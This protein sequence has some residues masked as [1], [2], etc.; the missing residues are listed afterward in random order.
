MDAA[1]EVI[2]GCHAC[3]A[4][5]NVTAVGPF[6]NVE[7]PACGAHNRVKRVLGPYLLEQRHS[8]GG[9]STVFIARDQTLDRVV[10]LKILNE[11]WCADEKRIAAFVEEARLTASFSHP[12]VVRVFRT[13]WAYG[14]FYIAMELV[15]GPHLEHWIHEKGRIPE[16][17]TLR[18]AIQ[19]AHGLQAAQRAGL[20]HR[21]MK[22]GNILLDEQGN[23]KIV[24]FGLALVTQGGSAT[25]QELWATPYYVPPEAVE[26][27]PETFRSDMY[28]FGATLYHALAGVPPCAEESM[29]TDKLREAKKN[30]RLLQRVCDDISIATCRIVNRAMAYEPG[31]RYDSYDEMIALLEDARKQLLAGHA[32]YGEPRQSL[33]TG[34]LAALAL[35][36]ALGAGG[37]WWVEHAFPPKKPVKSRIVEIVPALSPATS[38]SDVMQRYQQA[39][40]HLLAMEYPQAVQAFAALRDDE[41]T[42]EPTAT[43]CGVEAAISAGL[44]GD[45]PL[46]REQASRTLRHI[47]THAVPD[48]AVETALLPLLH[49]YADLP[50]ISPTRLPDGR[51]ATSDLLVAM[52]SG[53]KNW[54]QGALVEALPFFKAV[55][56][57]ESA[58]GDEW[59]RFYREC[60]AHYVEDYALLA[61][62]VFK[63]Y[64]SKAAECRQAVER[65]ESFIPQLRT[66]GRARFNIRAWQLDLMRQ[67][68][69]LE[70]EEQR[71]GEM[72]LAPPPAEDAPATVLDKVSQ[73][74]ASYGFPAAEAYLKTQVVS[75]LTAQLQE[76]VSHASQLLAVLAEDLKAAP[77]VLPL[78]LRSGVKITQLS[79]SAEGLL[80]GLDETG[81]TV[82]VAWPD[83]S[84]DGIISLHRNSVKTLRDEKEVNRRHVSA[85]YFD[86]LSGNRTRAQNAADRFSQNHPEFKTRWQAFTSVLP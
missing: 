37:W 59:F 80:T 75:P 28:A 67:A 53:L 31:D 51:M 32:G 55:A 15:P 58:P 42:Q 68:K 43:W 47:E 13:G 34:L 62:P 20:I 52:L 2:E 78:E 8:L 60:A 86:W 7:C 6:T 56:A 40:D 14:R 85:I 81:K 50:A 25:A 71:I 57:V 35:V 1:P 73:F 23:A 10:A 33:P 77:A 19:V 16:E 22:P 49:R 82:T 65:L 45:L 11:Q 61:D 83:L 9:M 66:R 70:K 72:K 69:R 48:P 38:V 74:G 79:A 3:G 54:E 63:N 27:K 36:M 39:K 44:D 24:D 41:G 5:M 12:N 29:A 4:G 26:G 17:E 46:A 18:M 30:V 84:P 21:D 64:P 76:G